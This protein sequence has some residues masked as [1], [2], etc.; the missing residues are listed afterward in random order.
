MA[1][2]IDFPGAGRGFAVVL[3]EGSMIH[4]RLLQTPA[5]LA[6]LD[7]AFDSDIDAVVYAHKIAQANRLG[8]IWFPVP[9]DA[10]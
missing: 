6:G 10:P 4:V 7:R 8:V 9:V 2:I 1:E 3:S 5:R